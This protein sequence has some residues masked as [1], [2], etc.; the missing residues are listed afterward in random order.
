MSDQKF[1]DK[2]RNIRQ[3]EELDLK[4]L[5]TYFSDQ[6]KDFPGIAEIHQFPGG[7]SNLTYLLKD[8]SD[9]EFVIRR[10]PFGAKIKSAHDMGREFN[11]LS[12]LQP[13]F[14][15]IPQPIIHCEDEEIIGAPF[16]MMTRLQGI[17][18][19]N[20]IP[21]GLDLGT[22]RMKN[23]STSAIETMAELHNI[24]LEAT[25]LINFGKPAG[26][27][28]RQV[29]GWIRRYYKSQTDDLPAMDQL[30][31]WMKANQPDD[32][33]A[34]FIHNDYKY[35][36]LVLSPDDLSIIGVL[37]WEMATVGHP[38]MDFGTTLAYW[39]E[40]KDEDSLKFF[41]LTWINGNLNRSDIVKVY[42]EKTGKSV[43]NILFHYIYGIFKISVIC[44]QIYK[45]YKDGFSKDPRFAGL[46]G[47]IKALSTGGIKALN[48]GRPS[49]YK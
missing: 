47:I 34:A 6:I 24:D 32:N 38:L 22:E 26:Y 33:R 46:I 3:G 39:A 36:N 8:K 11:V 16:Y 42:E 14:D 21:E 28:N 29:E 7:F 40:D 43:D 48:R 9:N 20:R 41:N 35:D 1:L 12:L 10:P 13:H 30:A 5:N 23:L 45:R 25:G 44:Q 4:K 31:E 2:A 18:L 15:K 19:R 27:V 17:I 49:N 37:D